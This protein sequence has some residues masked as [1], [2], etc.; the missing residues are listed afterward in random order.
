MISGRADAADRDVLL[1]HSYMVTSLLT[2]MTLLMMYV[3]SLLLHKLADHVIY[4]YNQPA[5]LI[6]NDILQDRV[7]AQRLWFSHV[8]SSVT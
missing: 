1:T 2:M 5:L 3:P 8:T 4:S 6:S 7:V